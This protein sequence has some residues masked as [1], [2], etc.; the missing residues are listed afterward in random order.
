M[1]GDFKPSEQ[2]FPETNRWLPLLFDHN[3]KFACQINENSHHMDF[4]NVKV[5]VHEANFQERRFL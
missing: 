2:I 5:V 4:G 1:S 3:S